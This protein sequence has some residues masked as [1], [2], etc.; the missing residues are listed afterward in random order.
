MMAYVN[1]QQT[2][3][4]NYVFDS[5]KKTLAKYHTY[6]SLKNKKDILQLT[7]NSFVE[8]LNTF[9]STLFKICFVKDTVV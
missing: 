1:I 8:R 4:N 5:Y 9:I 2:I 3:I 6:K 7:E